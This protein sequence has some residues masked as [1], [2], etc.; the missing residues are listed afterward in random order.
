MGLIKITIGI[1]DVIEHLPKWVRSRCLVCGSRAQEYCSC[2]AGWCDTC[3]EDE[4][5][6]KSCAWCG[7]KSNK[8]SSLF[9]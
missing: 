7:R 1:G 4:Y 6:P 3:S 9:V 2:G 8:L 5:D